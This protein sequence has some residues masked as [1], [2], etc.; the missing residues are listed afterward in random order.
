M[1]VSEILEVIKSLQDD[2]TVAKNVKLK[3]DKIKEILSENKE[4]SIK[5]NKALQ[6]LEFTS[7]DVNVDQYTRGQIWNIVSLLEGLP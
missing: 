4:M 7:E 5:V 3:L 2:T 1:T 6:E